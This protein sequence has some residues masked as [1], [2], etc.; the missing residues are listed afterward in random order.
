[1]SSDEK[2]NDGGLFCVSISFTWITKG[3]VRKPSQKR[4]ALGLESDTSHPDKKKE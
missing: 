2:R 4:Q 1:M 3:T